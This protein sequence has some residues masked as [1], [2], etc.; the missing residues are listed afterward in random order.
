MAV[1]APVRLSKVPA[2][3]VSLLGV[4]SSCTMERSRLG[5]VRFESEAV[6]F[7]H[8][9]LP[10]DAVPPR[11]GMR[12]EGRRRQ[13]DLQRD[14]MMVVAAGD[15]GEFWWDRPMDSACFY[16]TDAAL[17]ATVGR[18]P[19]A[20]AHRLRTT[21][22]LHDPVVA[23]LLRA[24]HDDAVAGQPHGLLP[25]D[26]LFAALAARLV[27]P[28]SLDN[29]PLRATIAD[30]RV[31]RA[32]DFIHAHLDGVLDLESIAAAAATSPFHLARC[33][34]GAVGCSIWQYVLRERAGRARAL[35]GDV[36]LTMAEVAARAGFE[37]YSSFAEAV[38]RTYGVAPRQ[39]RATG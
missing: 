13:A 20:R 32:L 16:F 37:T 10:L 14:Q 31:R 2:E 7:H 27:M 28:G 3:A 19:D 34:R 11:A 26:A 5:P 22:D 12:V 1:A 35:M 9:G 4:W 38:K 24:L 33:F 6:A 17:A 29:G 25:G 15:G 21:A 36:S 8:I 18:D 30:R 23:R 39:L